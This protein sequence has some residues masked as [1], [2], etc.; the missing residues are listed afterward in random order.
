GHSPPTHAAV[1]VHGLGRGLH[2][3]RGAALPALLADAHGGREPLH[4]GVR[5]RRRPPRV[6]PRP[7]AVHVLVRDRAADGAALVPAE[8]RVGVRRGGVAAEPGVRAVHLPGAAADRRGA[9]PRAV[10]ADGGTL[11]LPLDGPPAAGA[12]G[13]VLRARG[14]LHA[15]H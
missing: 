5:P 8:D 6:P 10:P 7:V 13:A 2:A 1:A 12:G 11:V 15:V 14:L 4:G 3:R 9:G